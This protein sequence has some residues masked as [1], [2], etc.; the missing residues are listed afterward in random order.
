MLE[1][2]V[3]LDKTKVVVFRRGR[4]RKKIEEWM[5]DAGKGKRQ[6]K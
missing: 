4:R 3:N 1:L 5:C 6:R 2:K